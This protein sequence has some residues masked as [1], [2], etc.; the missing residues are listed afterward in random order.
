MCFFG[1]KKSVIG[2]F[3][4]SVDNGA[5][6]KKMTN[7]RY[8]QERA[9]ESSCHPILTPVRDWMGSL[10]DR[11]LLALLRGWINCAKLRTINNL[12][13]GRARDS[14]RRGAFVPSSRKMGAMVLR[15]VAGWN[16]MVVL[17]ARS[18]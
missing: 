3:L 12:A 6:V 5:G 4:V 14:R 9:E 17:S 16:G 13:E 15:H 8:G 18:Q 1:V 10:P 7:F 2:E 11:E